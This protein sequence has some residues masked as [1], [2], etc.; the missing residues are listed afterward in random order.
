MRKF[1]RTL[2]SPLE[3]TRFD[4]CDST[5][6]LLLDAAEAGAPDGSV[7]VAREQTAGRGRRGR[8]WLAD[9]GC[10]LV[11]SML[12]VFPADPQGLNGLSLAV[13]VG[14]IRALEAP[15]LGPKKPGFQ[16][17]LKWPNDILLRGPAG[18]DA[19]VG[20]ILI[21]SVMR[22]RPDGGREM[23]VVIGVGLN[24]LPS[25]SIETAVTDQRV[26]ALADAYLEEASLMPTV[27]LPGVL[28]SLQQTMREFA[29]EGFARLRD[30][31]QA[32][33]LWQGA[34]VRI[35]EAG[36]PL[37]DG[38]IRGVDTDGALRVATPTGIERVITGDVSLRKV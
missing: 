38:E 33:H 15:T 11:F 23:A 16:I 36:A 3:I 13:G 1:P 19:K 37:L 30:A 6:R 17:G 28:A 4:S 10:T 2:M 5:N 24:C 12:R 35:S 26:A 14:I 18:H 7:Y 21:E 27:L 34:M 9:P 20:G 29:A 31:W 22:R 32:G 8:A 25:P